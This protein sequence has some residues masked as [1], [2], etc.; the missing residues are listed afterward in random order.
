MATNLIP[1]DH[2]HRH[3]EDMA[4]RIKPRSASNLLLWSVLAFFVIATTWA[5]LTR[6]DRAVHA[7]GRIV[8][9]SRLQVVSNL[10]GGIVRE[11]LVK[12]GVVVKKGPPLIRLDKTASGAEL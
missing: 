7:A 10:E 12:A 3:L 4:T 5:A 11:I 2:E 6:L 9:G 8:P 1:V